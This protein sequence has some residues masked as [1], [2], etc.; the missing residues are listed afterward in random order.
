MGVLKNSSLRGMCPNTDFFL[1]RIQENKEQKKLRIRTLFTQWLL[2]KFCK[3]VCIFT[4]REL[5]RSH[6]FCEFR[7][8]FQKSLISSHLRMTAFETCNYGRSSITVHSTSS[9]MTSCYYVSS[10]AIELYNTA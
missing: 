7:I 6:F 4:K 10:Y 3:T 1:V 9:L 2:K 8:I 5:H